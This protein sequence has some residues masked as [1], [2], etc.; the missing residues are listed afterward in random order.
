MNSYGDP[1]SARARARVP[2][3]FAAS[4][5]DNEQPDGG[6]PA[7]D[8]YRR[9]AGGRTTV[10]GSVPRGAV[11]ETSGRVVGGVSGRVPVA[12]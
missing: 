2:G 10:S 8:A 12:A 3:S 4:A 11:G 7:P 6:R 1:Q 9:G 5:P